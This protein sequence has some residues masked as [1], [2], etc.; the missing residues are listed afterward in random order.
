VSSFGDYEVEDAW[1]YDDDAVDMARNLVRRL[2]ALDTSSGRRPIEEVIGD[3]ELRIGRYRVVREELSD[4]ERLRLDQL[5]EDL[6]VLRD[7]AN[8]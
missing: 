3:I 8:G 5:I 4:R 7:R 2:D 1:D 6:E